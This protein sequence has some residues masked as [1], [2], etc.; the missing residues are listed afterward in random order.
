MVSDHAAGSRAPVSG[1]YELLNV[2]GSRT[3]ETVAIVEGE[4]LPAAPIGFSWRLIKV[5]PVMARLSVF[6]RKPPLSMLTATQLLELAGEFR[7]MALT[8]STPAVR[9]S[10]N[11]LVVR[12]VMLAAK[13]EIEES[14]AVRH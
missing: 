12:Y 11:T 14:R 1:D 2:F 5:S 13:R 7:A 4:F 8:A 3:G 10:L 6:D 9:Q